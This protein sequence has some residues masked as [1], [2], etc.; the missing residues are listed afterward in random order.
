M[1]FN[2]FSQTSESFD[3]FDFLPVREQIFELFPFCLDLR[4][5][6][7]PHPLPARFRDLFQILLD[8]VFQELSFLP[9]KRCSHTPGLH[10]SLA[11]I[12]N[13]RFSLFLFLDGY[14][15]LGQCFF[16][17]VVRNLSFLPS[18]N[19]NVVVVWHSRP[20]PPRWP[21]RSWWTRRSRHSR[22]RCGS[23]VTERSNPIR[24]LRSSIQDC[25]YVSHDIGPYWCSAITWWRW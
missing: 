19:H 11:N 10:I 13:S 21:R 16:L 12:S 4:N 9:Q 3:R 24:K 20:V 15:A 5:L 18:F 14:S 22:C 8:P 23:S 17:D 2:L 25:M 7:H 6:L 1:R